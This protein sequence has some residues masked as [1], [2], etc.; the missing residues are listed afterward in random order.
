[1][2]LTPFPSVFL[3]LPILLIFLWFRLVVLRL[4]ILSLLFVLWVGASFSLLLL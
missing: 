3:G 2:E 4:S 1:M